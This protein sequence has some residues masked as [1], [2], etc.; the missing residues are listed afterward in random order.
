MEVTD[1]A[2]DVQ[3]ALGSP[4]DGPIFIGTANLAN[5]LVGSTWGSPTR[6]RH[7]L[8]RYYLCIQ[9]I[10]AGRALLGH[11]PDTDFHYPAD[12]LTKWVS[13]AWPSSRPL[14]PTSPT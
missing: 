10:K 8:R 4:P 1:V 5:A 11:F 13:L 9:R 14:S 3:I 7:F 2:V 12:F 6:S